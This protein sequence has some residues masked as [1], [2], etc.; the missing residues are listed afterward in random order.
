MPSVSRDPTA[1]TIRAVDLPASLASD[2]DTGLLTGMFA[3]A[4]MLSWS[5]FVWTWYVCLS[6]L[7][8]RRP[9]FQWRVFERSRRIGSAMKIV[10]SHSVIP[11]IHFLC[12]VELLQVRTSADWRVWSV[13]DIRDVFCRLQGC[14]STA[15]SNV[16]TS[17]NAF[18]SLLTGLYNDYFPIVTRK[19]KYRD[20]TMP[21]NKQTNAIFKSIKTNICCMWNKWRVSQMLI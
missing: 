11:F 10:D 7:P 21:T 5:H 20:K 13:T 16:N 6:R 2:A 3:V 17:C 19:R 8:R 1:S 14:D 12:T 15:N 4:Y 9:A 18:N